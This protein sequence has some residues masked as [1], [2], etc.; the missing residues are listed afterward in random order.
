MSHGPCTARTAYCDASPARRKPDVPRPQTQVTQAHAQTGH[1]RRGPAP[2]HIVH[3]EYLAVHI[4]PCCVSNIA[5]DIIR[6]IRSGTTPAYPKGPP[7]APVRS[8]SRIRQAR[9]ETVAILK[10]P[11]ALREEYRPPTVNSRSRTTGRVVDGGPRVLGWAN[12][13]RGSASGAARAA[14]V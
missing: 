12:R 8:C 7:R 4:C 1:H 13:S 11:I 5:F 6:C 10:V 9:P 14:R 2:P 3:N